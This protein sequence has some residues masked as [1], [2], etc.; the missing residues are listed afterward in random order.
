[1]PPKRTILD[2]LRADDITIPFGLRVAG[3][4]VGAVVAVLMVV[5]VFTAGHPGRAPVNLAVPPVQPV[6]ARPGSPSEAT[7]PPVATTLPGLPA[8]LASGQF[9]DPGAVAAAFATAYQTWVS[10]DGPPGSAARVEPYATADLFAHFPEPTSWPA[11]SALAAIDKVTVSPS[12]SS[13]WVATVALTQH[14]L[15]Q[16][17]RPIGAPQAST[18]A[19]TMAAQPGGDWLV[20]RF[21]L[22]G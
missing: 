19:V 8:P 17:G 15:G 7:A 13:T 5:S 4:V 14:L 16:D 12:S 6:P 2:S 10:P 20:E 3:V 11:P 21:T 18:M 1:M 9:H 22:V